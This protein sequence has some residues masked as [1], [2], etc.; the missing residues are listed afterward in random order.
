MVDFQ[1]FA[2]PPKFSGIVGPAKPWFEIAQ[3]TLESSMRF[4]R[5]SA[6]DGIS[7]NVIGFPVAENY[8]GTFAVEAHGL[9]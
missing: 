1:M 7:T 9:I 6:V 8:S 5:R 4:D 3:P 2:S